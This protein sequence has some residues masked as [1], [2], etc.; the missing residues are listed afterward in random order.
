MVP[1]E[2]GNAAVANNPLYQGR[3][4]GNVAAGTESS[5]GGV[6][7]HQFVVH[8]GEAIMAFGSETTAGDFGSL[9][10]QIAKCE[11]QGWSP[12]VLACGM[13][14]SDLKSIIYDCYSQLIPNP[15]AIARTFDMTK[16]N[17]DANP[18]VAEANG[19][20]LQI[21]KNSG[22][23]IAVAPPATAMYYVANGKMQ[24]PIMLGDEARELFAALGAEE[25]QRHAMATSMIG[26]L[27]TNNRVVREF[28]V[29]TG[30]VT[31]TPSF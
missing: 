12:S 2:P 10:D 17:S 19:D 8:L 21:D 24:G 7:C 26:K 15:P 20:Y 3:G 1:G 29:R 22:V 14:K 6:T 23:L 30:Q 25:S 5:S 4:T 28:D 13:T 9:T 27:K 31:H 16:D 11:Q 18:P